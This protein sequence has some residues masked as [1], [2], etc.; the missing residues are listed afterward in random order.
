MH[1]GAL[2]SMCHQP[3]KRQG[4]CHTR[5]VTCEDTGFTYTTNISPFLS[6]SNPPAF[7]CMDDALADS[8]DGRDVKFPG[9]HQGQESPPRES[10]WLSFFRLQKDLS[11]HTGD[12]CHNLPW[13]D[14]QQTQN[15]TS[16]MA[17][18]Q[19]TVSYQG[20][21]RDRVAWPSGTH[22][23]FLYAVSLPPEKMKIHRVVL[24]LA[25]I[26]SH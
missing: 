6:Q 25:L 1:R 26:R 13:H 16:K 10:C 7:L 3:H 14:G 11:G 24:S 17:V 20:A 5:T 9:L 22:K 19:I 4:S 18:T 23:I 12:P 2:A 21:D 15:T 8:E